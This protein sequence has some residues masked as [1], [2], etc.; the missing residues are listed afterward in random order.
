MARTRKPPEPE[1]KRSYGAGSITKRPT[2]RYQAQCYTEDGRR[3]T[4]SFDTRRRAEDWLA[5]ARAKRL[6]GEFDQVDQKRTTGELLDWWLETYC[7]TRP[8][9]TRA[10][11]TWGIKTLAAP[12]RSIQA[13]RLRVDQVQRVVNELHE[14]GRSYSSIMIL[15]VVLNQA[16]TRGVV[17]LRLPRVPTV[18]L[19]FP[20]KGWK[21][22]PS[23]TIGQARAFLAHV[24]HDELALFWRLLF[25][26][27]LRQGELRALHWE[28]LDFDASILH[29]WY[30]LSSNGKTLGPT[31]NRRRRSLRLDAPLL[32]AI[33]ARRVE[34]G[35]PETGYVFLNGR[36]TFTGGAIR[37]R[38]KK[39]VAAAGLPALTPHGARHTAA[40]GMREQGADPKD[41]QEILGH[42]TLAVTMNTYVHSPAERQAATL[43]R[44]ADALAKPPPSG[45]ESQPNSSRSGDS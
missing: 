44:M 27:G 38:F 40:S 34:Q 14:A 6:A 8:G 11:Y 28:A 15:V 19:R 39:L 10:S 33:Q 42:S 16:F 25:S 5:Q 20:E 22:A 13:T 26:T 37:L 23:W 9:A 36:R 3:L 12:L 32:E 41:V 21:V 31:K 43:Q 1:P 7:A 29:V 2:G 24:E 45:D 30:G 4:R 35:S 17:D 18:G